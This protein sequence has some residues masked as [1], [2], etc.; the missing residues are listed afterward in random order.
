MIILLTVI[1]GNAAMCSKLTGYLM[2]EFWSGQHLVKIWSRPESL[3]KCFS[4]F[5]SLAEN[6]DFLVSRH[7]R[8]LEKC[9]QL[10]KK[11]IWLQ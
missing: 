4:V 10:T 11:W 1:K 6:N 5:S 9:F 8:T 2:K 3:C 7:L